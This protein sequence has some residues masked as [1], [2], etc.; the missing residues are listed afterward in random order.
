MGDFPITEQAASEIPSLPMFP[1]I[2]PEQQSR[3]VDEIAR[4][5]RREMVPV[6]PDTSFVHSEA[7]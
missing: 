6:P 5:L 4:F 2:A 7:R 3:V 1:Q